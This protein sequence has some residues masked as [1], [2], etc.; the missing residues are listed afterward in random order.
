MLAMV[1][2]VLTVAAHSTA[3]MADFAVRRRR[4]WGVEL[5][6]PANSSFLQMVKEVSLTIRWV[7]GSLMSAT[8]R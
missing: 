8:N 6:I 3:A 7:N 5:N 1:A 4:R 2:D